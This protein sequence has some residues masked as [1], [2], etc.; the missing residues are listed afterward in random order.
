MAS[1]SS[2][3]NRIVKC[4]ALNNIVQSFYFGFGSIIIIIIIIIVMYTYYHSQHMIIMNIKCCVKLVEKL[5]N[6]RLNRP[7]CNSSQG[8]HFIQFNCFFF[9]CKYSILNSFAHCRHL[10]DHLH[11]AFYDEKGNHILMSIQD[12]KVAF[13]QLICWCVIIRVCFVSVGQFNHRIILKHI[14]CT[15]FSIQWEQLF[16]LKIL[17]VELTHARG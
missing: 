17:Y 7:P 16:Q 3:N 5:S 14:Q 12:T 4:T 8:I 13:G 2:N 15:V 9:H 6:W 10:R 1:S 11:P